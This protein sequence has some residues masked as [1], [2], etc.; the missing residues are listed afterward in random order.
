MEREITLF[1]HHEDMLLP[2]MEW[3]LCWMGFVLDVFSVT[4]SVAL[5]V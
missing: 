2:Q 4:L 1:V 3:I 5:N